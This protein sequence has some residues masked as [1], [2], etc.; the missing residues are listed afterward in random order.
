MKVRKTD[1]LCGYPALTIRDLLKRL[2]S[3]EWTSEVVVKLLKIDKS[4]ADKLVN[5]LMPEGF[6]EPG[7]IEG[8]LRMTTKGYA[9]AGAS[10]QFIRRK[11][12]DRLIQEFLQRVDE[13]NQ[14]PELLYSIGE[15]VVF[16]SYVGYGDELGDVDL[17]VSYVRRETDGK[18][19]GDLV[20]QRVREAKEAGRSFSS[21]TDELYWGEYE[22]MLKLKNRSASISLHD[23][24]S[25]RDFVYGQAHTVLYKMEAL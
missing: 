7:R 23:L 19:Y 2:R 25:H 3:V 17:A 5:W 13:I 4:E 6:V 11:T 8:H 1:I 24:K 22:V 9:L 12:A 18:R 15:V 20:L 10:S 14:D 16:G 21:W